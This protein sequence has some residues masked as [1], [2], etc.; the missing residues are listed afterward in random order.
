MGLSFGSMICFASYNKFTN[1][2]LPDTL[3][4]SFVSAITSIIV[5]IFTFAT[6][7]NIA[8]EQNTSIEDVIAD[9]NLNFE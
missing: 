1:T 9:G 7:G 8:L 3:A 6:I 2:I 4:I 5:G